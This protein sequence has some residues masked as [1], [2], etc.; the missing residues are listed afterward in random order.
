MGRNLF[1]REVE[2]VPKLI[3]RAPTLAI[4]RAVGFQVNAATDRIC[5][6][7]R[8][9]GLGDRNR[10]NRVGGDLFDLEGAIEVTGRAAGSA[11][12]MD[13]YGIDIRIHPRESARG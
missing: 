10:L 4:E 11:G 1:L 2:G 9:R 7:F 3:G 5:V 6:H 13:R 8:G 12:T